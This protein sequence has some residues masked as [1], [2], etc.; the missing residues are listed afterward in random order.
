MKS[1]PVEML[2]HAGFPEH[3][4][5]AGLLRNRYRFFYV[6]HSP[7]RSMSC[8]D[9][10]VFI[11]PAEGVYVQ[12]PQLAVQSCRNALRQASRGTPLGAWFEQ[13]E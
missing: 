8:S 5:I 2:N 11:Q 3:S 6:L 9:N 1:I 12:Y 10:L 13:S 4:R 7:A